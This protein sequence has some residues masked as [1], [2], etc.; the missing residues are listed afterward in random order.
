VLGLLIYA[1]L[2][3]N[4]NSVSSYSWT[5][6]LPIPKE[7]RFLEL[8]VVV[9]LVFGVL[10][11]HRPSRLTA[12]LLCSLGAFALSA[13]V[14]TSRHPAA[15]LV[16]VARL[17][18]MYILPVLIFIIGREAP[19]A[20]GARA[21]AIAL[22]G[23]AVMLG[24]SSWIQFAVL[25]YPI[26][27]DIT[28][29]SASAHANGAILS[30]AALLLLAHGLFRG[31]RVYVI[32]AGLLL[33]TMILPSAIRVFI[34][35]GLAIGVMALLYATDAAVPARQ[36]AQRV[37]IGVVAVVFALGILGASFTRFDTR[38]ATRTLAIGQVV[39]RRPA[40]IGP[41]QAHVL[42]WGRIS[43][44]P[45]TAL[46]GVGPFGWG[47]PISIGQIRSFGA[48]GHFAADV[49]I[50]GK[51]EAGES[52]RITTTS[53]L[54]AEFGLVATLLA[55]IM[56]GAIGVAV[57]RTV[58]VPDLEGRAWGSALAC[59]VIV[60]TLQAVTGLFGSI[61][62]I[63]VSWPAMFLAGM[64]ARDVARESAARPAL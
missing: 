16:D 21:V 35:T 52:S 50:A 42:A 33:V 13:L 53:S 55:A 51:G 43:R 38:N 30:M 41:V 39:L 5:H 11:D 49:L 18:Y 37:G 22:V 36:R 25:H 63:S 15:A 45:A 17:C 56:Y 58:R 19:A 28:G 20:Q 64:R 54:L 6:L 23:W 60:F 9:G 26:G 27:D 7:V 34:F 32:A 29:L 40:L 8:L 10:T 47:N 57:W 59:F 24:V 62:V 48:L 31:R 3:D 46:F 14:S 2:F 61:E 12:G 4:A 1:A 44:D